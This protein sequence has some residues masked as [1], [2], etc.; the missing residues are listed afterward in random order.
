MPKVTQGKKL[1]PLMEGKEGSYPQILISYILWNKNET[2]KHC[3]E[4]FSQPRP[5]RDLKQNILKCN[6]R[7]QTGNLSEEY[8]I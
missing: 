1:Y 5:T 8:L 3:K 7:G 4:F 6:C 2:G